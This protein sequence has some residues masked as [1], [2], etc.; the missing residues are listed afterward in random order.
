MIILFILFMIPLFLYPCSVP[1]FRYALER[2]TTERYNAKILFKGEKPPII[3]ESLQNKI[4]LANILLFFENLDGEKISE[5]FKKK[6][7][8]KETPQILLNYPSFYGIKEPF[9]TT[10]LKKDALNKILTSPKRKDI[11][12]LLT[13]GKTAVWLF[14]VSGNL[15]KDKKALEL[16]KTTLKKVEEEMQLPEILPEDAK[17]NEANIPLEIKFSI[18]K[19]S[20]ADQNER[21]FLNMLLSV[22]KDLVDYKTEPIIFPIFGR[23]RALLPIVGKGLTEDL[24]MEICYYLTGA[25]SCEIKAQNPGI[26][27]LLTGDWDEALYDLSYI[28][29]KTLPPISGAGDLIEAGKLQK[30]KEEKQPI[31][32]KTCPLTT[33]NDNTEKLSLEKTNIANSSISAIKRIII[34]VLATLTLFTVMVSIYILKK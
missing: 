5:E 15:D 11:F 16:L 33:K 19:L 3:T 12:N 20:R 27:L 6:Y 7:A 29:E 24:I 17:Y 13:G 28:E 32:T 10:V 1:I 26:D 25:C 22:E 31:E 2:W 34:I 23:G 21:I 18:L 4:D 14:I 30:E 9:W 8:E